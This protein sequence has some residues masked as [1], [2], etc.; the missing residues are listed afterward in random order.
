MDRLRPRGRRAAGRAAG[1]DAATDRYVPISWE[2]AFALVGETLRGLESPD[3]ASFYTSGRLSNEA[4][5]LYQ[6][7]VR[8]FGTNNLPDCSNM[9]HEASGRALTAAL[10]TGK[11]TVDLARLGGRR[12]DLVD[13]RQRRHERSAD[14]DLA[15]RGRPPRRRSSC[16]STR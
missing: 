14:A 12:R 5:F 2:D 15:G 7:W 8:E 4:T 11:G 13:R 6:L 1:Y 10:G 9:C 3:E 16:M